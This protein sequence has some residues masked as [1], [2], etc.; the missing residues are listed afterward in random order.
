MFRTILVPVDLEHLDRLEKALSVAATLAGQFGARVVYLGVAPETPG[1]LGRNPA[2]F[3]GKLDA[4]AAAQAQAHGIA[5]TAHPVAA[6]DVAAE[7]NEAL[8]AALKRDEADLIVIGSHVPGWLDRLWPSHGGAIA[9]RAPCS[10]FV[11]R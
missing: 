3:A 6:H 1:P 8:L 11:V 5:A 7:L 4:F 2:E 10:V 9:A